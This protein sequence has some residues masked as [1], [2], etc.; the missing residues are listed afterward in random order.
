MEKPLSISLFYTAHIRGDL[1]LLPRLYTFL[2]R[3]QSEDQPPALL[4]DLGGAC[5]DSAWHCRATGGRS[6]LMALDA[7]GYHAANV[8]GILDR[9]NRRKLAVAMGLVDARRDWIYHVPPV[10]DPSIRATLQPDDPA[11][12]LQILLR[13]SACTRL[14][15]NILQLQTLSAGQIGQVRVALEPRDTGA[16]IEF[17]ALRDL[18]PETPPNP[19]IAGTVDFVLSEARLYQKKRKNHPA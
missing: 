4:L 7:M 10:T 12:R 5:A 19:S 9:E 11:A 1:A 2:R 16:R 14:D 15:G 17:A 6:T 8:A 18:P 13:P 3:L